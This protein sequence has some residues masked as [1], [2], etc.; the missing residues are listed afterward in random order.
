[1]VS[2]MNGMDSPLKAYVVDEL[3]PMAE[4]LYGGDPPVSAYV[5]P[6]LLLVLVEWDGLRVYR[7]G[8]IDWYSN[9]RMS[10][11]YDLVELE[12]LG[13]SWFRDGDWVNVTNCLVVG[14]EIG[15]DGKF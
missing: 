11:E 4:P 9:G 13:E 14:F 6:G 1:M 3:P 12:V 8:S 7:G 2:G 15:K 5:F 10:H